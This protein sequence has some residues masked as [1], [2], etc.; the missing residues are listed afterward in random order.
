MRWRRL[1]LGRSVEVAAAVLA[2]ALVFAWSEGLVG[3][4]VGP[5]GGGAAALG[6]GYRGRSVTVERQ[7]L[8]VV[9]EAMGTVRPIREA[10]VEARVAGVI[11]RTAVDAGDR[12]KRG[13]LLVVLSA[14]ELAAQRAS[15]TGQVAA[16]EAALAQARSDMARIEHLHAREAATQVEFERARTAL[17]I[18]EANLERARAMARREKVMAA[19]TMLRAPF[20]GLVVERYLDP[21]DLAAPGRPIVR[22]EDD[23]RFRLEA[24]VGEREAAGV[25]VGLPV[26]VRIDTPR[27]DLEAKVGEIVPAADPASRTFL[28]KVDLPEIEGLRSGLFGRVRVISGKRRALVVPAAA[29]RRVGGLETVRVIGPRGEVRTRYVRT[30]RRVGGGRVEVLAGLE[31][32]ERVAVEQ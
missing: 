7:E 32:G 6:G 4:H 24:P 15:A 9:V 23:S 21:G 1:R 20:D 5:E 29:V 17:K 3:R 31:A 22:I 10:V 8:P 2:L 18:A 27:L 25:S 14:P 28:V 26:R 30:G 12:V 19:Y 11:E 13:D 16:A